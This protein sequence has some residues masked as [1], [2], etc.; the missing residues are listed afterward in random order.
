M[1]C[2][3]VLRVCCA[4]V[5]LWDF[6]IKTLRSKKQVSHVI[7]VHLK[8]VRGRLAVQIRMHASIA[9]LIN[10][11]SPSPQKMSTLPVTFQRG[12]GMVSALNQPKS[13]TSI[14][15]HPTNSHSLT[16]PLIHS[17]IHSTIHSISDSTIHLISHYF[18]YVFDTCPRFKFHFDCTSSVTGHKHYDYIFKYTVK[19]S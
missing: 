9:S 13:M 6:P 7:S 8:N 2:V 5:D 10:F 14:P 18:L 19:G 11:R 12:R 3:T 1:T 15:T 16:H 4:G 17:I